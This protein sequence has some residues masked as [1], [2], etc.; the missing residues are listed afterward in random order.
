MENFSDIIDAF[1]GYAPFSSAIG[2]TE[3]HAGVMKHRNSI[4]SVYWRRV[5][6]AARERNIKKISYEILAQLAEKQ[7]AQ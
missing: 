7:L 5:V 3:N 6:E 2:I 1:G 4:P